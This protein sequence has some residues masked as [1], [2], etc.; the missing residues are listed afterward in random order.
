[1]S[2]PRLDVADGVATITLVDPGGVNALRPAV[3]ARLREAVTRAAE[4]PAVGVIVLR[5]D[6]RA[7]CSGGDLGWFAD[8]ADTLREEI[9]DLTDDVTAI[10]RTLHEG[11]KV[12]LAAVHGAVAGGG[13]G[14]ALACDLVVAAAGTTFAIAYGRIGAS[15]DLGVSA[16]LARDVGYRRA[17]ELCLLCER[18][19]AE[20]AL[21]LGIINRV[22]PAE[23][24]DATVQALARRIAAG[25]QAANA[26]AKRLLRDAPHT[27]LDEQ[28]AEELRSVA[29]LSRTAD[30][31]EGIDAIRG[32]R[33]PAFGDRLSR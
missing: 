22:V 6:A 21:A 18:H 32:G 7:F 3:V 1:M 24:L 25:P 5:A 13:L 4:D 11:P 9:I 27:P 20:Q 17:L 23:E 33:V 14:I 30:W 10:I 31:R 2:L 19:T 12:T 15:P 29:E 26:T 8:H 28:L 16:F